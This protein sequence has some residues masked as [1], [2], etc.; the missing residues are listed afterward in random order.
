MNGKVS[1]LKEAYKLCQELA[2]QGNPKAQFILSSM[3][4]EGKGTDRDP[5]RAMMWLR[6]A[7]EGENTKATIS[8]ID[9]L[10]RSESNQQE[11]YEICKKLAE[12]GHDSAGYRLGLFYRD[13]IGTEK[14]LSEAKK[15]LHSS[16]E[17]GN[18]EAQYMLSD[19]YL[20]GIGIAKNEEKSM[21]W[22]RESAYNGSNKSKIV[23]IDFLS[24]GNDKDL[25]EAYNMC[26]SLAETGHLGAQYRLGLMYWNGK[27]TEK[28]NEDAIMWITASANGGY[29]K[30]KVFLD[31]SLSQNIVG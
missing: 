17:R 5:E 11:A 28:S 23:L 1:D 31:K 19:M 16:A 8:L 12:T 25:K 3:L 15:W 24:K 6:S 29:E 4:N 20:K 22:L 30:A 27:G 2:E 14:N 21:F 7:V 26:S 13:G 18:E 10:S 9:I